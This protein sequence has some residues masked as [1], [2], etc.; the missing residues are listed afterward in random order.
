MHIGMVDFQIRQEILKGTSD[1]PVETIL[2]KKGLFY[3]IQAG[4]VLSQAQIKL[5]VIVVAVFKAGD[6]VVVNQKFI[7]YSR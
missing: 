2:P 1:L 7:Y 5:E 3:F 6:E 4:A